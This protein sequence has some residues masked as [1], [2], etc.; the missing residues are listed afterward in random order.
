MMPVNL[1]ILAL[2]TWRVSSLLVNEAGPWDAFRR[3]REL[4]GIE[5]DEEGKIYLVPERFFAQVL[6]CVWCAS[7]WVGGG[8]TLVGFLA[9]TMTQWLALP[10]VLSAGAIFCECAVDWMKSRGYERPFD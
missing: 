6:S 2:A 8:W 7:L 10:F 9:P 3:I 4:A 1:I 5:H